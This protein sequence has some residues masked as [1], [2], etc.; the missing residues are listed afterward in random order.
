[1]VLRVRMPPRLYRVLR[2][3]CGDSAAMVNAAILRLVATD[4]WLEQTVDA[5]IKEKL[6]LDT[7]RGEAQ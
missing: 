7:L 1:M 4:S 2:E 6:E 3:T 5:L